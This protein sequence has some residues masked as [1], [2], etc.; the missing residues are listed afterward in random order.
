[1]AV[2]CAAVFLGFL[3]TTITNLAVPSVASEFDVSAAAV[4]WLATAYVIPFA[5]LLAS[6]G[7]LA[8]AV[9]RTRL[10]LAGVAVY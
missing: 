5:A 8:D 4:T 1:L 2:S 7:A 10:L 3:D 6:A 9:G